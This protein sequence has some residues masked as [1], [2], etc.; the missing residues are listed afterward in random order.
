MRTAT[1]LL[2]PSRMPPE[3]SEACLFEPLQAT[4]AQRTETNMR[5]LGREND[6]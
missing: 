2:Q 3:A 5:G 1:C 4:S 6:L